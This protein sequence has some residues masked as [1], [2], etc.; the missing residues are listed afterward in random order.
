MNIRK[1]TV[2]V[3]LITA[4]IIFLLNSILALKVNLNRCGHVGCRD[5]F[6]SVLYQETE[7]VAVFCVAVL[8]L[9]RVLISSVIFSFLKL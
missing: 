3:E 1:F 5:I 6:F 2:N 8:L 9:R 7:S 4:I